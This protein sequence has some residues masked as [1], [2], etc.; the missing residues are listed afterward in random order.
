[1]VVAI[2]ADR[3]RKAAEAAADTLV[4]AAKVNGLATAAAA[5]KLA[6]AEANGIE[7]GSPV[8]SPRAV[9]AFFATPRTS[10]NLIPVDKVE[11]GGQYLVYAIRAVRDG[12]LTKATAE[13]RKQLQDQL[14]QVAGGNAQ[15]AYVKSARGQYEIKI[16]EDRL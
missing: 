9:E 7:R 16:A 8:P 4:K 1:M 2:R 3:Q 13:Q 5:A 15:K 6:V 14:A 11:L 12:D 10:N